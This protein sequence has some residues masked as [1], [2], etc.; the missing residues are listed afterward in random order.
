[1]KYIK[2]QNNKL[3]NVIKKS[4]AL[5]TKHGYIQFVFKPVEHDLSW[6]AVNNKTRE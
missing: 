2:N 4:Q 3:P 6:V 1:M 5:P